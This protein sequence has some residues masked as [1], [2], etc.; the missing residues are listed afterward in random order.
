MACS[1]VH[2]VRVGGVEHV[3]R[4]SLHQAWALN[5]D[6]LALI[7]LRPC[8]LFIVCRRQ[9]TGRD[10]PVGSYVIMVPGAA[11]GGSLK[12]NPLALVRVCVLRQ[13]GHR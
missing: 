3:R 4:F 5:P 2:T 11:P 1:F 7:V 9:V 13:A 6:P 10:C 8:P 12:N